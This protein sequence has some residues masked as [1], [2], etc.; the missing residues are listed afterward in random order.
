MIN[1]TTRYRA[2]KTSH[3][4]KYLRI[5]R[6]GIID[7]VITHG[8]SIVQIILVASDRHEFAMTKTSG[9]DVV[10]TATFDVIGLLSTNRIIVLQ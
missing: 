3:V 1:K 7:D 8:T 4:F 6:E 10:G 2:V 5:D 9:K